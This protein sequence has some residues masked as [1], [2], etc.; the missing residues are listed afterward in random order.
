M[1][2]YELKK[3]DFSFSDS[4]GSLTQLVHD[5]YRQVNV[6]STNS[7]VLRGGHYHKVCSE[8]FY[9][10][11]GSVE[12]TLRTIGFQNSEKVTFRTGDFF[13]IRPGTVHSM[14]FPED[15]LMVQMYDI[16]VEFSDGSKD[17]I[18]EEI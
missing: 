14:F 2:M 7:G 10:I 11:S 3:A 8:A 9:V 18:P 5:G 15:C 16:P 12:T 13:E 1:A 17:I 6:L 4:R